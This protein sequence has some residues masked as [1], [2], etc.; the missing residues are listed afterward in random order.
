M[1]TVP[2]ISAMLYAHVYSEAKGWDQRDHQLRARA[3]GLTLNDSQGKENSW[4]L[5]SQ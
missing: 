2:E 5:R 3:D 4:R 1:K